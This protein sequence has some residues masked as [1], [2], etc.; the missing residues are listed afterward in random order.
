MGQRPEMAAER[1]IDQAI[2]SR[3]RGNADTAV[4]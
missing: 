1:R 3:L 2:D 4:A